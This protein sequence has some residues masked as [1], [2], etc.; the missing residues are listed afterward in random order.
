MFQ[1]RKWVL[2]LQVTVTWGF[3]V[4]KLD[5][6]VVV[7]AFLQF[8]GQFLLCCLL[9]KPASYLREDSNLEVIVGMTHTC[10]WLVIE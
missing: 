7:Y 9:M 10:L 8:M 3:S 6:N 5:L 4:W 1:K 2:L